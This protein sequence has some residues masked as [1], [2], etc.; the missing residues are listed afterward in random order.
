MPALT[1]QAALDGA[2]RLFLYTKPQNADMFI[3]FV[4][5][6]KHNASCLKFGK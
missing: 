1:T 6:A 4:V 3:P 5:V 2:Y